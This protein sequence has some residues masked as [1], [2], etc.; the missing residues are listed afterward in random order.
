MAT[1]PKALDMTNT[2]WYSL[3]QDRNKWRTLVTDREKLQIDMD[4]PNRNLAASHTA[5][6][7]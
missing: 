5:G 3:A 6:A 1:D 2:D 4:G 7:K